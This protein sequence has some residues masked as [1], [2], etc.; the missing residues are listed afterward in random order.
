MFNMTLRH[1]WIFAAWTLLNWSYH[2]NELVALFVVVYRCR[3]ITDTAVIRVCDYISVKNLVC[4]C[5]YQRYVRCIC[6]TGFQNFTQLKFL[7]QFVITLIIY[8][9]TK[10]PFPRYNQ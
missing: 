2:L 9:H 3:Y 10:I 6:H 7:T 8:V 5:L 4:I 1:I